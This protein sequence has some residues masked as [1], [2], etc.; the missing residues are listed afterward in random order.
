MAQERRK[1]N[2]T[3]PLA[4]ESWSHCAAKNFVDPSKYGVFQHHRREAAVRCRCVLQAKH[5]IREQGHQEWRVAN[6]PQCGD[7][8][9]ANA[10]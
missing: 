8:R 4:T 1:A 3:E 9:D 6:L 7:G 10:R 2:L 5:A